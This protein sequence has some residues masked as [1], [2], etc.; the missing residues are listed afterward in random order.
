M[1]P[2]FLEKLLNILISLGGVF[3]YL[4]LLSVEFARVSGEEKSIQAKKD[5]QSIATT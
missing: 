5:E 2:E 1:L 3:L 4:L